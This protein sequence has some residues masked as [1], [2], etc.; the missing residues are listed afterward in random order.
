MCGVTGVWRLDRSGTVPVQGLA[1]RMNEALEHRGPDAGGVWSE[2]ALPLALGHRRLAIVD[3]S[4]AG[5]QPM[6]CA[7]GRRVLVLNGEIYNH[8]ALREEL[9]RTLGHLPW[10]GH[11]DT[12]T[13]LAAISAWGLEGALSRSV[14]MFAFGLWDR[15]EQALYLGRDRFGEKPLYYGWAGRGGERVFAFASELKA[16]ACLPGFDNPVNE[17]AVSRYFQLRY[18]PAPMTIY[19]G[20][21]KLEPGCLLRMQ[22]RAARQPAGALAAPCTHDTLE[23]KRWWS[24]S[25]MIASARRH[26]LHDVDEAMSLLEAQLEQTAGLQRMADVEVGA[27]LSGGVDSS[28]MVALLQKQTGARVKT[29][30][31]GFED[32]DF[33][34]SP[35]AR[36]VARHLGTDHTEVRLSEGQILET[37]SRLN[38]VYD[39]PFAD[40]SQIPTC[41]VSRVARQSVP[42]AISGD[43]GDELFGG[44]NRHR[45]GGLLWGRFSAVPVPWR[46]RLAEWALAVPEDRWDGW[47]RIFNQMLAQERQVSRWGAKIHKAAH[48]LRH[49]DSIEGFHAHVIAGQHAWMSVLSAGVKGAWHSGGNSPAGSDDMNGSFSPTERLMWLDAQR[50]L[51]DDILCKVDRAAMSVSLETRVPFLDHRVAELA[52]RLPLNMKIR[53]G[54]TKWV[55]REMLYRHVPRERVDRPKAGFSVPLAQWLRRPLQGWAADLL[56]AAALRRNPYLDSDVVAR[57][58]AEHQAGTHDHAD[59]LWTVLL[60]QQWRAGC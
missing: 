28:L 39:E 55:L 40:S 33:D 2:T 54:V 37:V 26:P 32:A 12:E 15:A 5:R 43:G 46:A 8:R 13:F 34:E 6:V 44:Y 16:L 3:L 19:Q 24:M 7:Q 17:E 38:S 58:W 29:F 4:D 42:V 47:G 20:V 53:G 36:A 23:L 21:Y 22:G 10:R 48:G 57:Y 14:G 31:V 52:W 49:A 45:W 9:D 60:F 18:V 25:E 27:F 1:A 11:S 35:H 51:P 50:Y 30:N 41:A 56:S 59:V